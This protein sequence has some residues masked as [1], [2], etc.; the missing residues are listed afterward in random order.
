MTS[1]PH[2]IAVKLIPVLALE[3]FLATQTTNSF[4]SVWC[5]QPILIT[6]KLI[7]ETDRDDWVTLLNRKVDIDHMRWSI[8]GPK[9]DVVAMFEYDKGINL[10]SILNLKSINTRGDDVC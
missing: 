9:N 8:V 2:N 5:L 4:S 7:L 3:Q 1:I 10:D 6:R